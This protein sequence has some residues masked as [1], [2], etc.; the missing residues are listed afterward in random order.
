M[1]SLPFFIRTHSSVN[2]CRYERVNQYGPLPFEID[3][4]PLVTDCS[5]IPG[6]ELCTSLPGC[7]QCLDFTDNIRVLSEEEDLFSSVDELE[8]DTPFDYHRNLY[9]DIMPNIVEIKNTKAKGLCRSGWR[10]KDCT[11][12]VYDASSSSRMKFVEKLF[13]LS[14]LA[15]VI[16]HLLI[17]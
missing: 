17:E 1:R 9:A 6:D 15:I 7:I 10:N 3:V 13:S 8:D 4:L 11:T 14:L 5:M 12:F 16:L 2:P